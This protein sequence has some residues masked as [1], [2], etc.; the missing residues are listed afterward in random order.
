M[1]TYRVRGADAQ[2]GTDVDRYVK[3]RDA[4]QAETI[5]QAE[6][7]LTSSVVAVESEPLPEAVRAA[8]VQE[9]SER[10]EDDGDA[11]NAHPVGNRADAPG[12]E[13]MQFVAG[14]L[15]FLGMAA[16]V[17]AG[18]TGMAAIDSSDDWVPPAIA[19][20]WF[21]GLG[22][23]NLAAGFALAALRDIAINVWYLRHDR[24]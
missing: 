3:A 17:I 2:D 10:A 11:G 19:A 22:L 5:A 20:G 18:I 14:V 13:P 21:L 24:R 12:Y 9:A 16:I 6:G 8:V 23:G 15:K 1:P 7:V 4:D